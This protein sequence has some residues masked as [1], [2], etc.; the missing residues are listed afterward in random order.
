MAAAFLFLLSLIAGKAWV[1]HPSTSSSCAGQSFPSLVGCVAAATF[2][3][4]VKSGKAAGEEAVGGSESERRE[5]VL[6]NK[7]PDAVQRAARTRPSHK[8]KL[9]QDRQRHTAN[10]GWSEGDVRAAHHHYQDPLHSEATSAHAPSYTRHPFSTLARTR[11]R[12]SDCNTLLNSIETYAEGASV[13]ELSDALSRL[14]RL[15]TSK[16]ALGRICHDARF[17][18]LLQ[19]L[20]ESSPLMPPK[21]APFLLSSLAKFS[22]AP[23]PTVTAFISTPSVQA[24]LPALQKRV[25]AGLDQYSPIAFC[26]VA[27]A[28]SRLRYAPHLEVEDCEI[29]DTKGPDKASHTP[30]SPSDPPDRSVLA[31]WSRFIEASQ[32]RLIEFSPWELSQL[33][34]SL[35]AQ[36]GAPKEA[37]LS[38]PFLTLTLRCA[39]RQLFTA[40]TVRDLEGLATSLSKIPPHLFKPPQSFLETVVRAADAQ[41][42]RGFRPPSLARFLHALSRLEG[43]SPDPHF[44]RRA[45][46]A[47]AGW[48]GTWEQGPIALIV[49]AWS[50]LKYHPSEATLATLLGQA[51]GM[52]EDGVFTPLNAGT[53]IQS[54]G[55]LRRS[56]G[57]AWLSTF[58]EAAALKF[59]DMHGKDLNFI[60]KGLAKLNW[61]PGDAFMVGLLGHM[62][63][64]LEGFNGA[65]LQFTMSSIVGLHYLP[66]RAFLDAFQAR[67]S[68]LLQDR[69][70]SSRN[71][72]IVLWAFAALEV[73]NARPFVVECMRA[74]IAQLE[75]ERPRWGQWEAD[76]PETWSLTAR[77]RQL[78]QVYLYALRLEGAGSQSDRNESSL[79]E[80]FRGM[81]L[82]EL[83]ETGLRYSKEEL[84]LAKSQES[85]FHREVAEIL[86]SLGVRARRSVDCFVL[87]LRLESPQAAEASGQGGDKG[88]GLGAGTLD[89]T[90][91]ERQD[92]SGRGMSTGQRQSSE[93]DAVRD[94]EDPRTEGPPAGG[95]EQEIKGAKDATKP[96]VLLLH[97]PSRFL[98]GLTGTAS[99][100][101]EAGTAFKVKILQTKSLH[102]FADVVSLDVWEWARQRT[103]EEKVEFLRQKIGPTLLET[104]MAPSM[105]LASADGG[106]RSE[107]QEKKEKG[108]GE[109]KVMEGMRQVM[110]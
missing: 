71:L 50:W 97:G 23:G 17:H 52:L 60:L 9:P 24:L 105:T 46:Q 51:R 56:P 93:G 40:F 62:R 89:S 12:G 29:E 65:D 58:C 27:F 99:P 110:A 101:M 19:R 88:E 1:L 18:L 15:A 100:K 22:T 7:P 2:H 10:G 37:L 67:F 74:A 39:E 106:G 68:R 42:P 4:P 79:A 80:E 11:L 76:A 107:K 31:W 20:V 13:D 25:D 91:K 78:R 64:Y 95:K 69:Q 43:F 77:I 45:E 47:C 14:G 70:V 16:E 55:E 73:P 84:V 82:V 28:F 66:H 8:A 41:L 83:L 59:P 81:G 54:L 94:A 53:L 87:D 90:G 57:D 33:V 96:L 32:N 35:M 5:L 49:Q 3:S 72:C 26:T 102:R 98:R 108:K 86:Q 85:G 92:W 44:L 6:A 104:Y 103:R 63:P 30:P 34:R 109:G 21:R 38:P 61:Y 75:A 48:T 36:T